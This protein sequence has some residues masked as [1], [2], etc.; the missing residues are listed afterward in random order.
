MAQEG[1]LDVKVSCVAAGKL[2]MLP[3]S[4][5]EGF[6]RETGSIQ[7]Q[8]LQLNKQGYLTINSQPQINGAS[9]SDAKVGWGGADG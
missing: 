5:M 6:H 7:D 9:S 8:L 1:E 3:W 4:E 2:S